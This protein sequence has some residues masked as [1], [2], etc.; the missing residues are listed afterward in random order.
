ENQKN[1]IIRLAIKPSDPDFPYEL[2]ALQLQLTIPKDYP[3]QPCSVQVLNSDI[4]KGFAFNLE[5]GYATHVD[6]SRSAAHQ[7]LVR[8]MNW[9]DRNMENLLQQAPAATVRFVSN[10]RQT[11]E[12][13]GHVAA[14]V[15]IH[16]APQY[17]T[18]TAPI[19]SSNQ[20]SSSKPPVTL[21]PHHINKTITPQ[22]ATTIPK[23]E[24]KRIEPKEA[25]KQ[26]IFTPAELLAA[27]N[28]RKQELHTLQTRFCDSFRS[29]NKETMITLTMIINDTDFTHEQMIGGKE[30]F[31]KYHIPT[32]YPLE[33]CTIEIENKKLDKTRSNWI[34]LGFNEHVAN[35]DYSLFENLNWLNR[36]LELLL[37]SPPAQKTEEQLETDKMA[38][39][40]QKDLIPPVK[41]TQLSATAAEFKPQ[42]PAKKSL[43]DEQDIVKKNKV[44]IVNDPSLVVDEQ[45]DEEEVEVELAEGFEQ[46]ALVHTNENESAVVNLAKPN[47]RKGTEIRLIDPPL[48]N[49]SL[50]RC[51][52]LH[53][54]VKCARCKDTV[55]IE[56][57]KPEQEQTESKKT[58][59]W[60]TCPTCTSIL[61]VKFLGEFVHQGALSIGLLQLAG[62]S[63]YDLLPSAYIGTCGSCMV[64]MTSTVRL[65]PHDAPRTLNCFSCHAKM[66][67]GLGDYKFVKIGSEGGERLKATEQQ[68][69]KLKKKKSKDSPLTIGE[70][71]PD[72][73]TCSHYRKSKRWFRFTCC[74][75]LYPCDHCHDQQQDHPMEMAKRMVCGLCSREQT[76]QS[77]RPCVCGNE[78]EKAPLKGAFWEGGKG[79]RDKKTMSRKDPHKHKGIGK[80]SSK[81]Q[82]R[83][84]VAGKEKNQHED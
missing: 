70:P 2:D 56:N 66:T 11:K 36:H 39:I 23:T 57:I 17:N 4:P 1:S 24:N 55:D 6:P 3:E 81:K 78:F 62:C 59:R 60:T 68:V 32:L 45:A 51:T 26:P 82:E 72:Q 46:E 35:G 16:S 31:I 18:T 67:C 40:Q 84:G 71:L 29:S 73:G 75:K 7:T 69:M 50:F 77:G 58:E 33:P 38:R 8:Q 19:S 79:V 49:I 37:S 30:L 54:L 83:V 47:V 15:D 53:V 48:E 44:I 41:T 64:D 21:N 27:E 9:L 52:L 43:F 63:A 42:Q 74:N 20:S 12:E 10:H 80:T 61:G 28:R 34:V 76:I 14:A 65:S 25:Q 13:M 22:P 5:K